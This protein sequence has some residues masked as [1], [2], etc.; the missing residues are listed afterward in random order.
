MP[1]IY[2]SII[3]KETG[4]TRVEDVKRLYEIVKKLV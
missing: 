3:D 4:V 1:H 2:G